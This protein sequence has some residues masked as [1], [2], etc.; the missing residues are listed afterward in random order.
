MSLLVDISDQERMFEAV[1]NGVLVIATPSNIALS[2]I[3]TYFLVG[4]VALIG[5]AIILCFYPIMVRN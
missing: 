4:P 3:Y 5:C 2:I 1:C